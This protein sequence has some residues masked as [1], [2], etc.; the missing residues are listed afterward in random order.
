MSHALK[1]HTC[2]LWKAE[3]IQKD[4]ST[5]MADGMTEYVL[6]TQKCPVSVTSQDTVW[7]R[8]QGAFCCGWTETRLGP[9]PI[10]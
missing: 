9:T 8:Q 1:R 4:F 7:V 5:V 2:C 6:E 10:C 3:A